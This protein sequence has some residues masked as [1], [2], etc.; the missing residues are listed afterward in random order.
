[1]MRQNQNDDS[2]HITIPLSNQHTWT[3]ILRY[4]AVYLN[5][6]EILS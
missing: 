1:M 2:Q 5:T 4:F 3:F 6:F